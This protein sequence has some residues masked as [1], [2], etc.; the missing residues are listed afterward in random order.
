MSLEKSQQTLAKLSENLRAELNANIKRVMDSVDSGSSLWVRM[1]RSS[2]AD[3]S[4][5][6]LAEL[7]ILTA[8]NYME[9][10][11]FNGMIKAELSKA[12]GLYKN[13]YKEA[14]GKGG[15]NKE[16]REAH[17]VSATQEEYAA[18]E[19]IK[20]ISEVSQASENAARISSESARKLLDKAVSVN[21]G[22]GRVNHG[23][24]F[25]S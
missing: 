17:A 11:R 21:F 8:N 12:E 22:E 6:E 3:L 5:G 7:V 2:D 9:A 18:Y 10:A 13:K 24:S 16:D 4:V 25:Q 14:L 1:V 19:V 23:Q 20:F 15:K